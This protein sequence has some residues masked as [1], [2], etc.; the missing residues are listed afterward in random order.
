MLY[1]ID[2]W[3]AMNANDMLTRTMDRNRSR[4]GVRTLPRT[5]DVN[6]FLAAFGVKGRRA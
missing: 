6:A 4:A 5:N 1:G 3:R 2:D